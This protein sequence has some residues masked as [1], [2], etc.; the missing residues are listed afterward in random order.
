MPNHLT[1]PLRRPDTPFPG[2]CTFSATLLSRSKH[3]HVDI[4]KRPIFTKSARGDPCVARIH[5]MCKED[6]FTRIPRKPGFS[7]D[8]HP[9][10]EF[11]PE[12]GLK[13]PTY[14]KSGSHRSIVYRCTDIV[15][16]ERLVFG[17]VHFCTSRTKLLWPNDGPKFGGTGENKIAV[18]MPKHYQNRSQPF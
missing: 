1:T 14:H 3:P 6:H 11:R 15:F 16:P 2:K 12:G 7:H 8:F 4:T 18:H 13:R 17:C 10:S 5:R 9:K